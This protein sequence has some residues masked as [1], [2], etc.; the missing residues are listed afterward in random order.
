MGR[1]K[2]ILSIVLI[3]VFLGSVLNIDVFAQSGDL[4][5]SNFD[6]LE[7][8]SCDENDDDYD[9]AQWVD[10]D[11][12]HQ[13]D[14]ASLMSTIKNG[15]YTVLT[16]DV[17]GSMS[18]SVMTA[19]KEAAKKFCSAMLS[20]R[21]KN[22]VSIVKFGSSS[23]VACGF[24]DNLDTLTDTINN[25]YASGGTDTTGGLQKS[26][27]VYNELG[28]S[29]I[30]E[31]NVLI[32]SDG[33]PNSEEDAKAKAV[34][35]WQSNNIY[36]LGY[37][38]SG[39]GYTFMESIQNSGF[40][41]ISDTT[42]MDTAISQIA[43]SILQGSTGSADDIVTNT[44]TVT[45]YENK[46]S[47]TALQGDYVV[48]EGAVITLNGTDYTSNKNGIVTIP[49]STSGSVV[50][51]KK[52]YITKNISV[53]YLNRTKCVYLEKSDGENPLIN[54]L[55]INNIELLYE[56]FEID[57]LDES[58]YTIKA[59]VYCP[60]GDLKELYLSQDGKRVDFS[61]NMLSLVFKNTFDISESIY[62]T[63]VDTLGHKTK[64][65]LKIKPSGSVPDVVGGMKFNMGDSMN[66]TLPESCGILAGSK[67]GMGVS[68]KILELIPI[69][70]VTEDN[71]VYISIGID[72]AS[73][74]KKDASASTADKTKTANVLKKET[75]T[76][77][78]KIEDI[79]KTV[80]NGEKINDMSEIKK[81]WTKLKNLK[82]IYGSAIKYP[83]GSFGVEADF[84]I[85]GFGEGYIDSDGKFQW[86][87]GGVILCP[88]AGVEWSGT[89]TIA[90]IP[91][92]LYWEAAIKAEI[93]ARMNIFCNTSAKSFTPYGTIAGS[94]SASVGLGAGVKKVL[95]A[96]GGITGTLSPIFKIERDNP[97][98]FRLDAKLN[99][100]LKVTF[101]GFEYRYDT[102]ILKLEGTWIEHPNPAN[103]Q[104]VDEGE[105]FTFDLYN[106]DNY[107]LVSRNYLENPSEFTANNYF[108][109]F[110]TA[111]QVHDI[112][113]N[114]YTYA[115]PKVLTLPDSS[116]LI[117]WL[118]DCNERSDINRTAVYYTYYKDGTYSAP[119]IINDDATADFYPYAEVI[120]GTAYVVWNNESIVLDDDS[121]QSGVLENLDISAAKFD[122]QSQSFTLLPSLG[123]ADVMDIQ[124]IIFGG[125]GNL[126]C[127]WITNTNNSI[128]ES[129][130][131]SVM[132][133]SFNSD[134]WDEAKAYADGLGSID[135]ISAEYNENG[136]NIAYCVDTDSDINTA[137]DL[138]LFL[139][140]KNISA[141]DTSYSNVVLSENKLYYY[142]GGEIYAYDLSSS[143]TECVT[144]NDEMPA[145]DTFKVF[146]NAGKKYVVTNIFNGI[147][148]ELYGYVYD[149]NSGKWSAKTQLTDFGKC[150]NGYDA[151]I[152]DSGNINF[153]LSTA[154]VIGDFENNNIYGAVNLIEKSLNAES[155]ISI[156]SVDFDESYIVSGNDLQIDVTVKN[157]GTAAADSYSAVLEDSE[158]NV[159]VQENI[160]E[161]LLPGTSK[162][163]SLIYTLPDDFT[164]A[165]V[166]VKLVMN[167]EEKDSK[168]FKLEYVDTAVENIRVNNNDSGEYIISAEIVNRGSTAANDIT[169]SLRKDSNDSQILEST[170]VTFGEQFDSQTVS[171]T[172]SAL[173]NE[174]YYITIDSDDANV[175][176]NSA[177][178]ITK[179][180]KYEIENG[181]VTIKSCDAYDSENIV[182][183]E[184]IEGY[185]VTEIGTSAYDGCSK[186]EKI[187]L[188]SS[189]K[190]IADG[191]FVG[192]EKLKTIELPTSV[193]SIGE[194]VFER[195]S[196]LESITVKNG[197]TKFTS[198]NGVLFAIDEN[199]GKELIK[200]PQQLKGTI[201]I[202]DKITSIREDAFN[203]SA[204]LEE[205]TINSIPTGFSE[206]NTF[207]GCTSLK[208]AV[209]CEGIKTVGTGMFKDCSSLEEISLPSSVTTI[210]GNS[211]NNCSSLKNITISDNVTEIAQGAFAGCSA[212]ESM[213]IPFV[214]GGS[215]E[216]GYLGYIFGA[217]YSSENETYVPATLKNLS[218][219][220]RFAQMYENALYMCKNIENVTVN[221]MSVRSRAF[222]NCSGLKTVTMSYRVITVSSPFYN[223]S[224]EVE[225]YG[226]AGSSLEKYAQNSPMSFNYIGTVIPHEEFKSGELGYDHTW[227]I[228]YDHILEISGSGAMPE[229]DYASASNYP[230][231]DYRNHIETIKIGEN[232]MS[233]S[234][235]A[236][237]EEENLKQVILAKSV[238]LISAN[239]FYGDSALVSVQNTDSVKSIGNYAFCGC[240]SLKDIEFYNELNSIGYSAFYND[241][242]LDV[243][244]IP[245][246]VM[247]IGNNAFANCSDSFVIKGYSGTTAEKYAK[248]NKINF[249]EIFGETEKDKVYISGTIGNNHT[250]NLTYSGNLIIAGIGAMPDLNSG[251]YG[252][253]DYSSIITSVTVKPGVT[254]I[255]NYAF[256]D[257]VNLSRINLPESIR[258]IG[259]NA[260]ADCDSL[261]KI[262]LPENFAQIKQYA[263]SGCDSLSEIYIPVSVKYIDYAAFYKCYN[264]DK[265]VYAGTESQWK[266]IKIDSYNTEITDADITYLATAVKLELSE[267]A[268]LMK[269]GTVKQI[270]AS[271]SNSNEEQT[272]TWESSEPDIVSV[273]EK[274]VLT[275]N[276][277][278]KAVITVTASNS[279]TAACVVDVIE[280]TPHMSGDINGDGKVNNQDG[281]FLL[282]HLAGWDINV[283]E[284]ALDI[285]NDSAVNNKDATILL[286]YLAGWNVNIY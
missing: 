94:L 254:G 40:Y 279:E 217:N 170:A 237:A 168:D 41:N 184:T 95:S 21:G 161:S 165:D 176:N 29:D 64:K 116:K 169:V 57:L 137:E 243:L 212:I 92:P 179:N 149:E 136:K 211:F 218:L 273:D 152:D 133:S 54:S 270:T 215:S 62:V 121:Q 167:D 164:N 26:D 138:R 36:S 13:D 74:S 46:K 118:D 71:K 10:D 102:K 27:E 244:T 34:E 75:L 224:S 182:I 89:F 153:V 51:A 198:E 32:I 38:L 261:T 234:S 204:K 219:T 24:T 247:T 44:T 265:V 156:E 186:A 262:T 3:A 90:P 83:K 284:S 67:V 256:R 42:E 235:Y 93:N 47:P 132:L 231:Y 171:F 206:N 281:T 174:V 159:L 61:S 122:L 101:I 82:T 39:Y 1:F 271:I 81:G 115:E 126:S 35:M 100:Y 97:N 59:E 238:N 239:A 79:F 268:L 257:F 272:F 250:W 220:N 185:P 210:K 274:G 140:G 245:Y 151:Y 50:V 241:T 63:A 99:G 15:R 65:E 242:S 196:S 199:G 255:G 85:L 154:E 58:S 60:Q 123:T 183:P 7:S 259:C 209:L 181:E 80:K 16:I 258:M 55:A 166:S 236:F 278:G 222:N 286:R 88:S 188:P 150:I 78:S 30:T 23:S 19:T 129:S 275:A 141:N 8:N 158:G 142:N 25:L 33:E 109:L 282:R 72:V 43:E 251:S 249:E 104:S 69:E 148:S 205:I 285:N 28:I 112:K 77:K 17:S 200:Y 267:Y 4:L 6:T 252:Y 195:C 125:D 232:V 225:L 5:Q 48:S 117:I 155:K 66:F 139:N 91:I 221:N 128:F 143:Q 202:D 201:V 228:Y 177:Y 175:S 131:Y 73:Y 76:A 114:V 178:V 246:T 53:S 107:E 213:T 68:N 223:C 120:D 106:M 269:I 203:S 9:P 124:P 22:Y 130:G 18:G 160:S 135:S 276:K 14:D 113:T 173:S 98:Y 230:W 162:T 146:E 84:T 248:N 11:I 12:I 172:I 229:Y 145:S 193:E 103:T 283:N 110:D 180:S 197:N 134:A 96:G 240:R 264:I 105:T 49:T 111:N 280:G 56:D 216:N 227:I 194:G 108:E 20:S 208:K 214:G 31:R 190:K 191:A 192:C 87:D 187:T 253:S 2:R 45:V 127:A 147:Y 119:A 37:R 263:F 52:D 157:T 86:L 207:S 266:D 189:L 70:V 277:V 260:F 144:E 233:V 226:Y 163:I